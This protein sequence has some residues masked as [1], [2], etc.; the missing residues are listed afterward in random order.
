MSCVHRTQPRDWLN[1]AGMKGECVKGSCMS[2]VGG[3][4]APASTVRRVS[5]RVLIDRLWGADIHGHSDIQE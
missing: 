1:V 5:A 4:Q 2:V 3:R